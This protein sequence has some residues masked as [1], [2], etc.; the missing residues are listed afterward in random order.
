MPVL[1]SE[2]NECNLQNVPIV[3]IT[4]EFSDFYLVNVYTPNAK[5]D[6]SRLKFREKIW[7]PAFLKYLKKLEKKKPFGN[8]KMIS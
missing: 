2:F 5:N 1:D 7:D 6:L 3:V 4:L 8:L